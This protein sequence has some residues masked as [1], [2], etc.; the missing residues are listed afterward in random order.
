MVS[1]Q[2]SLNSGSKPSC[3][4]KNN[5]YLSMNPERLFSWKI[6]ITLITR[7]PVFDDLFLQTEILFRINNE[8]TSLSDY[9]L[10]HLKEAFYGV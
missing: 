9:V 3:S 6:E 10:E 2:V 7:L 1:Y 4:E 5:V 8:Y